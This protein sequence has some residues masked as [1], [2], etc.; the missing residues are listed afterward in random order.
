MRR[1]VREVRHF[2]LFCG[3]GGGAKGF[4]AAHARVGQIEARFRCLGGVDVEPKAV[5]DFATLA[6]VPGTCLDL[7]S[8][9][10]FVGFHGREPPAD[11]REA[12]PEDIRRAAGGERPH[13]VFTSPPCKGFSGL[14][15]ESRTTAPRYVALN[16]LTLRGIWLALEAWADDP[17]EFFLLENVPR[18][19]Q[20]GRVLLDRIGALLR[21]YG[22]LVAETAPDCGELGNLAQTRKRFLLVARHVGKVRPFLYQPERRR[23]RAVG[24]VLGK[25]PMPGDPL[26]GPMHR[27]PALQWRTWVRLAF[28]EAGSDWRSLNKLKVV[29]GHLADFGLERADWHG[30]VLGVTPWEQ[31]SATVTSRSSPTNGRYAVADPRPPFTGEYGQLGLLDWREPS[32]TVGGQTTPGQGWYSVA[33]PRPQDWPD[34]RQLGVNGWDDTS[35]TLTT[36]R[37]PGKGRFT[38]ADPR[39]GVTGKFNNAFLVVRIGDTSPAVI[40][41]PEG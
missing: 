29:D 13:I 28:V 23:L 4:N 7:F 18:I 40:K 41:S 38:V 37:A 22:Y 30:G 33:D 19:A 24:D 31:T 17:P 9:E 12:S 32:H 15:P 2:H 20:R 8:R 16:A 6:G 27:V 35:P 25:M 36:A 5:A 3:L 21:S 1:E 26:S 11:W 39:L 10:Q 34:R 14:L